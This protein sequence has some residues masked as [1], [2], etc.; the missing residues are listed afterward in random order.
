MLHYRPEL[1]GLAR[2]LRS[3]MTDAESL[4]WRRLRGKQIKGHQFYRQ[5][6][7][8]KYIVDF[9]SA[10]AKLVVEVDGGQHCHGEGMEKDKDRDAHLT[11]Q[12]L[13][14]LR[15]SD[16]DVLVNTEAVLEHI[17]RNA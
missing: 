13:R 2:K 6:P 7:I 1:K 17:W 15:F 16:H 10:S 14:V 12:G 4:L 3:R 11:A 5:R 8:E 9:Y